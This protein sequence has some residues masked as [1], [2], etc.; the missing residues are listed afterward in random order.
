MNEV[1]EV[2][3]RLD[4]VEIIGQSIQLQKAGRT[5]KAPCPFHQ[6]K[7]PSFVVSPDRQSWHCFGACGTGGDVISFVMKREGLDFPDALRLL[8]DRAGVKLPERGVSAEQDKARQRITSANEAASKYFQALLRT[9]A[10]KNAL[11]YLE[12]RG[13]D[14]VTARKFALGYSATGWEECLAH[15]RTKGFSDREIV[16]A[17]LAL[18]G[19]RGLHDRFRNRLMFAVWNPKG[20]IIGFGARALDADTVPKYLNTGQTPLFDKGGTLYALDKAQEAIRREGRAVVVEGYMDVIAAHQ[21]GF[22]NVV[23]QMGTALTDRQVKLLKRL[24]G[25]VVLALDADAAGLDAAV[26]GHDVVRE[27]D[28]AVNWTGLVRHQESAAIEL[29]VAVLPEGRDPDDVVRAD[30]DL[31]RTLVSEAEPVLDFRLNR[32]AESHNL[33]DPRER[34]QLARD[35]L[36]LL[37]SVGDPVVRAHYLQR[38]SRLAVV[39]EDELVTM[40]HSVTRPSQ[41]QRAPNLAPKNVV[42]NP[43]EDFLLALLLQ[44]PSLRPH[45]I[46]IPESLL[47]EAQSKQVLATWKAEQ[48]VDSVKEALPVELKS[49]LERLLLWVLPVSSED[50]AAEALQDCVEKLSQRRLQA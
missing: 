45:G 48:D 23:A 47:W 14:D 22:D 4:I 6:E 24:T 27:Q 12:S 17:G 18:Q 41:T 8:A 28:S 44:H 11:A 39:G 21:H 38:L 46:D 2:K 3:A 16:D 35:F 7:T 49:Y 36:P 5:F 34:S 13:V 31:W 37:G 30:P 26:R 29:R 25:Q 9:D 33:T 1:E 20:R 32:A 10:G 43:R 15:L 42:S 19:E 40:M 50:A